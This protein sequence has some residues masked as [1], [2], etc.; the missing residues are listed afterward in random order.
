MNVPLLNLKSQYLLIKEEIDSSIKSILESQSFILGNEV[1]S[2]KK[3]SPVS[4]R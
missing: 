2:W 4:V 3:T 1:K